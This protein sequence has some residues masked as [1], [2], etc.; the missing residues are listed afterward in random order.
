[1]LSFDYCHQKVVVQLLLLY[2]IKQLLLSLG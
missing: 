2:D 1:L